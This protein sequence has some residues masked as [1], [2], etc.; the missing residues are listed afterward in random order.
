MNKKRAAD[1]VILLIFAAIL[2][3]SGIYREQIEK[4]FQIMCISCVGMVLF[5]LLALRD[6]EKFPQ[7]ERVQKT[8]NKVLKEAVLLSEEDTELMVWDLYGRTAMVIGREG[9][10]NQVD[11]DLRKS[12]YA[13]MVDGEHAVLNFSAGQWF[14]EDLGSANGISIK[15]SDG[16]VYRLAGGSPCKIER[17]DCLYV[18]QNRLLFR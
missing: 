7:Q 6:R 17:R 13:S 11:I 12:P 4:S 8:D 5:F 3:I 1:T 9:K 18:G 16:K 14:V 10:E 2:L 15:K